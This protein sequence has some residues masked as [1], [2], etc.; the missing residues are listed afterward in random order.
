MSAAT[1]I[2]WTEHTA[3]ELHELAKHCGDAKQASRARAV[4]MIMDG[5]SR[6][7][8]ARAQ[9]MELQILRDWVLRYNAEG[10]E[11]LADRPR[12]GSEGR[13]TEAQ[14]AEVGAWIEAGPAL[15]R[16]GV[17]R[18]RVQDIVR[19][20]EEAFG[21]TVDARAD[22]VALSANDDIDFVFFDMEHGPY[23]VTALRTWMQWLVDPGQIAATGNAM[24]GKAVIVRIPAT[25]RELE[26]NIWQVKQV[27]DVGAHGVIFP[28]VETPEQALMA[29]RAMRYPQSL[30]AA[31]Q[32]PTGLRGTNPRQAARYWGLSVPDYVERAD[33]WRLDRPNGNLLPWI[34]IE[35]PQGVAN[36][37]EIARQL[38]ER[39][40]G[41]V[42]FA[43]SE[44]GGDMLNT[45]GGSLEAVAIAI[46][47]VLA[48][49]RE[50]GLPVAMTSTTNMMERI[51]QGARLFTG[52]VTPELRRAAG[53][54]E[55]AP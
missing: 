51:E 11:G 4:A 19:K 55:S 52:G 50:F 46:D 48:A 35:S 31:D 20:I 40:I 16:D 32:E 6:T 28:T 10:F 7:E 5:A 41:A 29:I 34:L 38:S 13:L 1:P 27:L 53:R 42:L 37:R 44:T 45:H 24:A 54:Q 18:W 9:G 3:D 8:A 22:P 25:G 14:I 26:Q 15:E 2:T 43:G 36:V 21:V 39:N 17:T 30:G 49:G 47:T 12:G 23:D 33:V